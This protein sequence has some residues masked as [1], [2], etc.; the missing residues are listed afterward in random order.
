VGGSISDKYGPV[1]AKHGNADFGII[2]INPT[3][4]IVWQKSMGGTRFE[5]LSY[6][7]VDKNDNVVFVGQTNSSDDDLYQ[8]LDNVNQLM[9]AG[10]IGITNIIKGQVFVDNNGNHL[11]D[12]NEPYY[13]EGRVNSTKIND[14]TVARIFNGHYLNNLDTGNYIPLTN[15]RI[16]IIPF[17]LRV[18]TLL[19]TLWIRKI[20]WTLLWFPNPY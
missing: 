5:Y 14:T 12:S 20:V 1:K 10:K 7:Q 3:G 13:S 18:I 2:K 17:F 19:S 11:K 6:I 8:Q 9:V 4:D 15:L 16:I